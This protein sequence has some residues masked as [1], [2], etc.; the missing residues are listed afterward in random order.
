MYL[1]DILIFSASHTEH[2]R[3]L[4]EVLSRLRKYALFANRKKC[5]FFA[6]EVEFLGFVV[7]IVGV[8]IDKSRVSAIE[9]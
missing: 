8:S 2:V 1:D 5:E 3:H 9:D 4:G 6:T 7:S